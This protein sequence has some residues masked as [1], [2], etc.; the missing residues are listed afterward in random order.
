MESQPQNPELRY[1]ENFHY[2][3][4]TGLNYFVNG[5]KYSFT[6]ASKG[7]VPLL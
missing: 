7:R 1:P 3:S 2:V 6:L 4:A 5:L